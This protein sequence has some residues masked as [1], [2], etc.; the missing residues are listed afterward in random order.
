MSA[1][2]VATGRAASLERRRALSQGKRGLPPPSER[3]R[4]GFRDAALPSA[5]GAAAPTATAPS[6]AAAPAPAPR[7]SAPVPSAVGRQASMLRRQTLSRGKAAL[8]N[9]VSN[10]PPASAPAAVS[11]SKVAAGEANGSIC[12]PGDASASCRALARAR[13]AELARFGRGEAAPAPNGGRQRLDYAPKVVAVTTEAQQRVTGIRIGHATKVTGVEA[14]LAKPISGTPYIGPDEGATIRGTAPKVG[15][16]RTE[17]G[18]VVSGT[19]VRSRVPVTGDEAGERVRI[20]GEADPRLADD[21]T[22]RNETG[23]LA[24]AQFERQANPHGHSV[25]GTNLGRSARW[26]GS[27]S[28]ERDRPIEVTGGGQPVTGTAVGRSP[29]VTGDEPGSCR[30]LT[31][32]QYLAPARAVLA[33]DPGAAPGVTM[34]PRPDPA[35]GGKVREALTWRGQRVTGP[36]FEQE[37]L[38]TGTE[39]GTCSPVTGT[40]YQGVASA[41]RWCPPQTAHAIAQRL[42]RNGPVRVTGDVPL[43]APERVSGIERGAERIVSGTPYY[44]VPALPAPAADGLPAPAPSGFS[45][46]T[47]HRKAMLEAEERAA[48]RP[49]ITGSFAV[50]EGKVTG[51][52][53]FGFRP[54]LVFSAN[55]GH[56][57]G[58]RPRITGEGRTQGFAITGD[59]WREDPRITGTEGTSAA[60]RNPTMREGERK[61]FAHSAVFK[62]KGKD[63][64]PRK[65]VT[66]VIGWT[67]KSAAIVTLSGG[68]Q[69]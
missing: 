25:F 23:G 52:L 14:G 40:P 53:D 17:G 61:V 22:P 67:P 47:P 20:T 6:G 60:A 13:R 54:R 50:G 5:D 28:R 45:I 46:T 12:P 35:S 48:R 2:I 59:A 3:V 26:V 43:S 11:T 21:L 31:G 9:S 10:P 63:E 39:P 33:C 55:P 27:R 38:V 68:A 57:E 32:T 4:T 18:L 34:L 41:V 56:R 44:E 16:A 69:G 64:P 7:A 37:E 29:R 42:V 62:G 1:A 66:G 15:V 49:K 51:Q 36:E 58:E 65:L 24:L 30:A 8:L 19:L